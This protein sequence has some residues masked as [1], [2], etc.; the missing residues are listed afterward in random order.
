MHLH[1]P[2]PS[3]CQC[4]GEAHGLSIHQCLSQPPVHTIGSQAGG[5]DAADAHTLMQ[6]SCPHPSSLHIAENSQAL[7]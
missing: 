3:M 1:H 6:R 7:N 5:E 2:A 4:W